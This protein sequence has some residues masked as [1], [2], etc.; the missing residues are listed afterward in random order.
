MR[1]S[2]QASRRQ[3]L[4]S[5]QSH[6]SCSRR[7]KA[8]LL[9][10]CPTRQQSKQRA[11]RLSGPAFI[12]RSRCRE[13]A[14]GKGSKR[15]FAA[16][17]APA[18]EQLSPETSQSENG[19]KKF[20]KASPLSGRAARWLRCVPAKRKPAIGVNFRNSEAHRNDGG[21]PKH[22]IHA[23]PRPMKDF[24]HSRWLV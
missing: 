23:N 22:S 8:G 18:C 3:N 15:L 6:V 9:L 17:R 1:T 7:T 12:A 14:I 11:R 2:F 21:S 19:Q 10:K 24:A 13:S 16:W 20:F 5:V 4:F